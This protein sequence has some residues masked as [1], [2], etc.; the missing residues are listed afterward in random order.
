[1][2]S[3]EPLICGLVNDAVLW[4]WHCESGDD[5]DDGADTDA[6]AL[7]A[8]DAG[9]NDDAVFLMRMIRMMKL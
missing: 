3:G 5:E 8:K 9:Y 2:D 6:A 7:A 4:R 1:M